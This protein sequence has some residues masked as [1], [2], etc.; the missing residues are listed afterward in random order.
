MIPSP[1]NLS[2]VPSKRVTVSASIEKKRLHD[3]PPLLRVLLLGEVH[4]AADVGEQHR[5]LL[6]F[7]VVPRGLD[8]DRA[9]LRRI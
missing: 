2:T 9:R 3:L 8:H 6:A 7:G 5:H 1:V 4:R